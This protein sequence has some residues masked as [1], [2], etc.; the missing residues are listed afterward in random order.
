MNLD[1]KK[2]LRINYFLKIGIV[3]YIFLFIL[4]NCNSKNEIV[5]IWT[6]LKSTE[7][8]KE[9]VRPDAVK[10]RLEQTQFF[11]NGIIKY[12]YDHKEYG[13]GNYFYKYKKD[14][15]YWINIDGNLDTI[16]KFTS[17]LTIKNDTMIITN[18]N[19]SVSFKRE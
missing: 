3:F 2:T 14:T 18:E 16:G 10:D 12:Y 1:N 7:N 13:I 19:K 4:I 5:G 6:H 11:E 9:I 8:G 17:Y 15:L